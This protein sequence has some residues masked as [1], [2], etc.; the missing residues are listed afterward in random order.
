MIN[1]TYKN[2][3]KGFSV[4]E[5]LVAVFLFSLV[6]MIVTGIFVR[7]L[8]LQ[9]RISSAQAIQDN[10]IAVLGLMSKEIRVGTITSANSNCATNSLSLSVLNSGGTS[11]EVTYILNTTDGVVERR[12]GSGVNSIVYYSSSEDVIFNSLLFCVL[13]S[14]LDDQTSRVTILASISNRI[15]KPMTVRLQSTLTSRDNTLELQN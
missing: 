13:H 12:V 8:S 15:G 10:A 5:L 9:R 11:D 14:D 4:I 3:Q 6:A 2:N 7:A 1:N